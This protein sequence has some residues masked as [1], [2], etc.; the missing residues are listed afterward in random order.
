[1]VVPQILDGA[2]EAKVI[3]SRNG[4]DVKKKPNFFAAG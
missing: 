4:Y 2:C 1:M 3:S